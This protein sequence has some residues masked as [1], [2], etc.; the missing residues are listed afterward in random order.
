LDRGR[1]AKTVQGNLPW[2]G[3]NS[4][5]RSEEKVCTKE[6]ENTSFYAREN[7]NTAM[8][9]PI[10]NIA[11]EVLMKKVSIGSLAIFLFAFSFSPAMAWHDRTHIAVGIVAQF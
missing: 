1:Q 5:S 2:K 3:H 7:H 4:L 6:D 9:S 8:L 10:A 11:Q